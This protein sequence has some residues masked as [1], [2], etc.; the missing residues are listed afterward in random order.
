MH[1][2]C[3]KSIQEFALYDVNDWNDIFCHNIQIYTRIEI[4]NRR[5]WRRN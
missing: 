5:R 4:E 2:L 1:V 3:Q